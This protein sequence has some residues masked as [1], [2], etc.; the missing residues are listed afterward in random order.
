MPTSRIEKFEQTVDKLEL[1]AER[2]HQIVNGDENT[3]VETDNGPVSSL[4][5]AVGGLEQQASVSADAASSSATDAQNSADAASSSATDAQNSA[6]A[7]SSS[8]TDAQNSADAASSSATDAQNSADAA[9]SSA[10]D[11]QN[12]ADATQDLLGEFKDIYH[13]ALSGGA[14]PTSPDTGDLYFDVDTKT[15]KIYSGSVWVPVSAIQEVVLGDYYERQEGLSVGTDKS[16][17]E[18]DTQFSPTGEYKTGINI[19]NASEEPDVNGIEIDLDS[20]GEGNSGLK[21]VNSSHEAKSHAV[22]VINQPNFNE[23][24]GIKID[25]TSQFEDCNGVNLEVKG[26]TIGLNIGVKDSSC[27]MK[28]ENDGTGPAM[29]VK[30]NGDSFGV[31]VNNSGNGHGMHV[32]NSQNGDGAHVNNDGSGD[33]LH[34]DNYGNGNGVD[35]INGSTGKGLLVANQGEGDAI[36]VINEG[37]GNIF[38]SDNFT[39]DS[40]GGIYTP[41]LYY[42]SADGGSGFGTFSDFFILKNKEITVINHNIIICWYIDNYRLSRLPLDNP[43]TSVDLFINGLDRQENI[44]RFNLQINDVISFRNHFSESTVYTLFYFYLE[45]VA[46]LS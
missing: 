3:E 27:G 42:G 34:V 33:G 46:V 38:K 17:I 32:N 29:D 43:I 2:M 4:K 41:K 30:I 16:Q 40:F 20:K 35:I 10:T 19:V 15:L 1:D 9:S 22:N 39:V 13:G 12:S 28:I 7:A 23:C 11:A 36:H 26:D 37:K 25:H 24:H 5:R 31:R 6:D 45:V 44:N 21:V 14:I 8:A 18:V